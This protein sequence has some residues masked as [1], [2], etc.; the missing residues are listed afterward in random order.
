MGPA[1][2]SWRFKEG[3]GTLNTK[4]GKGTDRVRDL[5][6]KYSANIYHK[7][8]LNDLPTSGNPI[9]VDKQIQWW[10]GDEQLRGPHHFT[11]M[12]RETPDGQ[13][14]VPRPCV[15]GQKNGLMTNSG[16]WPKWKQILGVIDPTVSFRELC[17]SMAWRRI[18]VSLMVV[19][20]LSRLHTDSKLQC[21]GYKK[22]NFVVVFNVSVFWNSSPKVE[23]LC[24]GINIVGVSESHSDNHVKCSATFFG[25]YFDA[26]WLT[27]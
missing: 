21:L 15:Q 27:E 9:S 26:A 3:R 7:V 25:S 1:E 23:S 11:H 19:Q 24:F 14:P 6:T 12:K 8:K 18:S 13:T 22:K 20:L 16:Q 10:G 2:V 17:T 5:G 4:L